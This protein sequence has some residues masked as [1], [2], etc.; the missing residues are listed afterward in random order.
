MFTSIFPLIRLLRKDKPDFLVMHL[1]TL[2][3]LLLLQ[4]FYQSTNFILRVS[5]YPKLNFFRKFLWKLSSNKIFKITC[6]SVDLIHQLNDQNIFFKKKL[7][8]L[9]DPILNI[10]D[11][12]K[13]KWSSIEKHKIEKKYFISAGRLTKQKN[14]EYLINEFKK[15]KNKNPNYNLLIFGEG[16]LEEKLRKKINKEDLKDHVFLMGYSNNIFKFMRNA[17]AFLLSSLWEDPGFVIIEAAMCNLFVISS[18]CK[19]GPSEFLNFGKGGILFESNKRGALE[20][21]LNEFLVIK[22]KKEKKILSKKNCVKYTIYRHYNYL[23]K[24]LLN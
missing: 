23:N 8:F 17:E 22:N 7:Y 3:P 2:L 1:I 18:N 9:P 14:F 15:F 11:F 5:G 20:N 12:V 16:E 19:N 24:I 10:K 6:P 4:F 13:K 21:S